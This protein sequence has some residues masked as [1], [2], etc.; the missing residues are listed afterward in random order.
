VGEGVETHDFDKKKKYMFS[1]C[2]ENKS[3]KVKKLECL[4]I[5]LKK[6]K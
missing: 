5:N 3:K 6:L 4:E 1:T 2:I